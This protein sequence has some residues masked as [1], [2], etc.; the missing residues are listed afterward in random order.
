MNGDGDGDGDGNGD[1]DGDKDNTMIWS[2]R[3]EGRTV[4]WGPSA[5]QGK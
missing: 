4:L 5:L 3:R 1:G 2:G